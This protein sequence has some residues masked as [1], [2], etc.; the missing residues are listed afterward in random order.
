MYCHKAFTG[1]HTHI[2]LQLKAKYNTWTVK[3]IHEQPTYDQMKF[4]FQSAII[5]YSTENVFF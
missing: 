4:L 5:P 3:F 2:F 1:H